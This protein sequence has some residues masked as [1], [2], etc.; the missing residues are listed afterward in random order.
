MAVSVARAISPVKRTKPDVGKPAVG[1]SRDVLA[2]YTVLT[3]NIQSQIAVHDNCLWHSQI[4]GL[5]TLDKQILEEISTFRGI[6]YRRLS[7]LLARRL[8]YLHEREEDARDVE[9]RSMEWRDE[10]R[11]KKLLTIALNNCILKI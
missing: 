4:R 5:I 10:M 9:W 1:V 3:Y 11:W 6:F 2:P 8:M 7:C